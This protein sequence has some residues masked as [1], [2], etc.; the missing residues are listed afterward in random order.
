M[1]S[2]YSGGPY[3]R[4]QVL[5][6]LEDLLQ[7]PGDHAPGLGRLG[8]AQHGVG[9]AGTGLA[10]REDAH[11]REFKSAATETRVPFPWAPFKTSS[12]DWAASS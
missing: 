6:G 9:L 7:R 11:L 1:K 3:L 5:A 10:V 4:L 12:S 2:V 8:D